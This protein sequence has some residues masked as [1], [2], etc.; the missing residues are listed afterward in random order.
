MY[1]FIKILWWILTFPAQVEVRRS[2]GLPLSGPSTQRGPAM[3][4]ETSPSLL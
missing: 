3:L 1:N 2:Q 4:G